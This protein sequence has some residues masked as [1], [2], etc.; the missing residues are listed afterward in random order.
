MPGEDLDLVRARYRTEHA[1]SEDRRLDPLR[2]PCSTRSRSSP[3]SR[4]SPAA[5][6][7]RGLLRAGDCWLSVVQLAERSELSL[8]DC[9]LLASAVPRAASIATSDPAL[10]TAARREG[11]TVEALPDSQGRLP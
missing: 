4:V 10:A 1:Q 2:S 9:V 11:A 6:R 8:A 7:V 3:S 5:D